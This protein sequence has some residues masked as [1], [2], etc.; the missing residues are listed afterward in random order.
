MSNNTFL[1]NVDKLRGAKDYDE[2]AIQIKAC[3]KAMNAKQALMKEAPRDSTREDME[4]WQ[5]A[6]NI[7]KA[8]LL[9]NISRDVLSKLQR[10]GW[11]DNDATAKTTWEAIRKALQI[12]SKDN[13]FD[14]FGQFW[15]INRMGF[16][17][18]DAFMN[19][20]DK[21]W[22]AIKAKYPN[23][24]NDVYL[25]ILL[26]GIQKS[27]PDWYSNW[28]RDIEMNKGVTKDKLVDFLSKKA[29]EEK[30]GRSIMTTVNNS[31]KQQQQ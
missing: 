31:S 14:V 6:D 10:N 8:Y 24:P 27:N 5:T 28:S 15:T 1:N 30:A 22:R 29:N 12:R 17:S 3:L 2:W 9:L 26:R 25:D 13:I 19:K 21:L 4:A 20:T 23:M 16:T 7:A 18:L 11:D